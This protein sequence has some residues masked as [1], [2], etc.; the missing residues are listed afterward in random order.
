MNNEIRIRKRRFVAAMLAL[1]LL[2]NQLPPIS[3]DAAEYAAEALS[4]NQI[5]T[6][7]DTISNNS[8]TSCVITYYDHGETGDKLFSGTIDRNA[9]HEVPVYTPRHIGT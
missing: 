9:L 6:P 2:L 3:A 1:L 4:S 5:L 8:D 7:G